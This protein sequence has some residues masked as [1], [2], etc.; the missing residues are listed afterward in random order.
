MKRRCKPG[1]PWCDESPRLLRQL[2][3]G[4]DNLPKTH[5]LGN[6]ALASLA[7]RAGTRGQTITDAE[8][9]QR[10]YEQGD[11]YQYGDTLYVAGSHTARDWLDDFTKIPVWKPLFGG[12]GG[13]HRLQMAQKAAEATKPKTVVGHSL[14]GAVALQMQKDVPSLQ[15]RTYGAPVFDP[16]GRS[17]GDR[18][19]SRFDPVSVLDRGATSTLDAPALNVSGFHSYDATAGRNVAM[20]TDAR[21]TGDAVTITE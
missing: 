20:G 14:G 5:R 7:R 8:G 1:D 11:A 17:P 18:Y 2:P 13:I 4:P 15:T 16:L 19:R 3:S 9:L 6:E 12:S 10:A 21:I